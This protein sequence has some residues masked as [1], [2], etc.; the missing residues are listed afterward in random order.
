[1][2]D[3]QPEHSLSLSSTKQT[4]FTVVHSALFCPSFIIC[5]IGK[6]QLFLQV[7]PRIMQRT[8]WRRECHMH[9]EKLSSFLPRTSW[10]E[11]GTSYKAQA[12]KRRVEEGEDEF[13]VQASH[14]RCDS[15]H[16][17]KTMR[18]ILSFH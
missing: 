18:M 7:R 8:M 1:M 15:K 13:E 11:T 2:L 12:V 9:K 4:E 6:E 3:A 16:D 10:R 5:S 14:Q 17:E